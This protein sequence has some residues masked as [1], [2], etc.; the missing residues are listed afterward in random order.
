MIAALVCAISLLLVMANINQARLQLQN[1]KEGAFNYVLQ[2]ERSFDRLHLAIDEYIETDSTD[3]K[4]LLW[5]KL[6]LRFDII[7]SVFKVFDIHLPESQRLASADQFTEKTKLFLTSN[8]P[9]FISNT[10]P[11]D[12]QLHTVT[13]AL[14]QLSTELHAVGNEVFA[15]F[16][17]FRDSISDRMEN[18]YRYFWISALLLLTTGIALVAQLFRLINHSM[19]LF[20]EA[21]RSKARLS[22]VIEELRS[23]KREQKAKDSFIAAASH[24][25]RQPLHALGLFVSALEKNVKKPEGPIILDKIKQSTDALSSLFN[26]LLDISRLDAGVVEVMPR[27]FC[28]AELFKSLEE[29]FSEIAAHRKLEFSIERSV[30]VAYTDNVLLG[31][32]LRNLIDNAVVHTKEGKVEISC[33]RKNDKVHI[34]V[35]D[36]GPGIPSDE[37][38]DIF[39]EYY[40]L[41]NPERDRSKGLG[42]GLSIVR[43]LS[44]LLG[45]KVTIDSAVGAGTRIE[46]Q[47]PAGSAEKVALLKNQDFD[48]SVRDFQ[49]ATLLV[50][51]DEK[52]VREGMEC[53]LSNVN[54]SVITAESGK[55]A[56]NI[57]VE[58]NIKPAVIIADY[59]L[60]EG[61]TGDTAVEMIRDEFNDDIPALII[62]GDTSP[63]RVR[64]A[65]A[66][67]MKLLHK[68]VLPDELVKVIEEF[69]Q[70]T[71]DSA[72]W[73]P[74]TENSDADPEH[75]GSK[76][77]KKTTEI[78]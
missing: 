52:A 30:E 20:D 28:C 63:E 3:Q 26:S 35:S 43:R 71:H 57:V 75:L 65:T 21:Q 58:R 23:G 77:E 31:R 59:R 70:K 62:T 39:S 36:T 51:D 4:Q 12:H 9:L 54:C 76:I 73:A 32:I 67:G 15:Q 49:G 5:P 55:A 66:S 48:I 41:G 19:Q 24:D 16:N 27:H 64:D 56:H 18:L 42:L 11:E 60:R 46:L 22:N 34:T 40:Q 7:W 47:V 25:L 2:A 69:L 74:Y 61:E 53:M 38:E 78:S 13:G 17:V 37:H 68:P 72:V 45:I 1:S 14:T 6:Q 29:E 33:N 8:D 10:I 50:I 44:D